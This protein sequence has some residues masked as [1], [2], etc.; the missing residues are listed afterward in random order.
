MDDENGN[1]VKTFS[2]GDF[3]YKAEI[4]W[5]GTIKATVKA[6]ETYQEREETML[7]RVAIIEGGVPG[8][9]ESK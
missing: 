9:E 7:T 4:G 8:E 5:T 1:L 3:G 2:S 6:H